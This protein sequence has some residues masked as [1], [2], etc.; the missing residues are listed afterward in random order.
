MHKWRRHGRTIYMSER[1][2]L[3]RA[4]D[5]MQ[6]SDVE[7]VITTFRTELRKNPDNEDIADLLV[8][9]EQALAEQHYGAR[10]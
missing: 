5:Y 8:Y 4:F 6:R 1:E 3:Q 10:S 2:E 9:A 7:L